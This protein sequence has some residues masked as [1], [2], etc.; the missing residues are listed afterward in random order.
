MTARKIYTFRLNDVTPGNHI[1]RPG[2]ITYRDG[3]LYYHDGET[4]GG[5]VIGGGG[6]GGPTSW[7][8]VTG[9]PSFATVATSGA[10]A[11]LTGKPTLFSGAY[12]DLT[13]KPTLFSGAY[14]DLS[15]KPTLFSGAYADLTGKP[16]L[17]TVATS[18]SYNDLSNKPTLLKGDTGATGAQGAKGD[19]GDTGP[20]GPA[21]A[22]GATGATGA[23]GAAG[24]QGP[25]GLKGDT[26]ATGATGPQGETGLQGPQGPAG[27]TG[28]TGAAGATGATGPI[29]ATGDAGPKGDTGATGAQGPQGDAGPQGPAGND[30]APGATG[31]DGEPG[32]GVPAG[33]TAGQILA[34][35]SGTDYDT[36]WITNLGGSGSGVSSYNDL[37]DK[38]FIP[39]SF[40][41]LGITAGAD[42]QILTL[43]SSLTPVWATPSG[44]SGGASV[45]SALEDVGIDG[46]QAGQV[47]TWN[48][49]SER[50]ENQGLPSVIATNEITNTG[51]EGSTY[52]VSVGTDGVVT[53]VTS[54]GNLEFGALPEPGGPTHFHIMR[55]A[56]QEGS[57]D[58]YFG[59]D[60]NYVKLPGSYGA[61]TLGVEIGAQDGGIGG[62]S[63]WRFGTDGNIHL[64]PGG[65]ILDSNSN[66]VLGGGSSAQ[67]FDTVNVNGE[68]AAISD[69]TTSFNLVAGE[70]ISITSGVNNQITIAAASNA[71]PQYGYFNELKHPG[72]NNRIN[73]EA[74]AMDSDGNSYVSYSYYD[75]NES[76]DF[77]GVMK[78]DSTG[79]KLW[80][81]NIAS[82][83]SYARYVQIASLEYSTFDGEPVLVALGRYYD[84]DTSKDVAFMCYINPVSGSVGE[85]L[86]DAELSAEYG[87]V[88]K[89]GVFGTDGNN[90][91]FA[92]IVGETYSQ[93]VQKTLT[94]LAGSTVDKVIFSW[95]DI[96]AAGLGN[97]Q[98]IYFNDNG[99][100][101]GLTI[102]NFDTSAMPAGSTDPSWYGIS[103]AISATQ[104]GS[105]VITRVNGWGS[106]QYGWSVPQSL[107]ILGSTLGGVDGVND[108]TFDFDRE[109]FAN[110]SSNIDAAVSNIQGTPASSDV[111]CSANGGRD[112]ANNV[113][114][115]ITF[116]YQLGNQA[117]IARFGNTAS[118]TKTIGAT[119]YDRL[120]SVV[121][122]SNG[123]SYAVGYVGGA[124]NKSSLVIK[125]D[126]DG[127]Q[128][129]AV[130]I[131]RPSYTGNE[132]TS[133]DLLGDG[134]LITVD[135]DGVVTKLSS[136]DGS[137]IW[138]VS[139]D[140]GPSW[141]GNFKGTSTPDGDYIIVNYEDNDYTMYVMKVSGS[142]GSSIWNK[143][144][145]RTY[146]GDQGEV[147]AEDDF[148]AQYIDCNATHVTIAGSSDPYSGDRVGLVFS[149]PASGEN[150][151]GTYGQYVIS[152]ES[153]D[154]TT[155][156]TTSVAATV[157][158]SAM[159]VTA[160]PTSP[161]S[162]SSN[163]TVTQTMMGGEAVVEPTVISWTN[164]NNNV[165]RI[166]DYNGG[167]AVNYDGGNYDAKWFDIANHTSGN[168]NFRGAIIQYHAYVNGGT[169]I[170]TIHL[171]NDYTQQQATHT[172]HLSGNSNLQFVTLWDCNGERGQLYFKTTNGNGS[173]AMIQWTAKVFYGSENNC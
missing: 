53:M 76:K 111:V 154:W 40:S 43:N 56:G 52:S 157:T 6:S 41:D 48:G 108:M 42:G 33:G 68:T 125:Y 30:G 132:L 78:F 128:Q 23:T 100:N 70:G 49:Q 93:T 137:I 149:F 13:G 160:N 45:L 47:L 55:P 156:S 25:Q 27:A 24:A 129:W 11:D 159:S 165:W 131:D 87:M 146:N 66:S 139:A 118:W 147:L 133:I 173:N 161:T 164:P 72:D 151:D 121:V 106:A 153:L 144:I 34:K 21:G 60:Y 130:Y 162:T 81:V 171:A 168:S 89:D 32:Q 90:N 148:N 16:S 123:Y 86:I 112:W 29:G 109:V 74:V 145:T 117:Y 10:Y 3:Y 143:R 1:G 31:N 107:T 61:G 69:G 141:D 46:V 102:N 28:D 84:N 115:P 9:K 120:N 134:N 65:N 5:E 105:Y 77:G 172:E 67:Y 12:V 119:S 58:L 37:T 142:D 54:R 110:N 140:N 79:A 127:N 163:I 155:Q 73:G 57:S 124:G 50:W 20:Q 83:N 169:I 135:E 64:P 80:S 103:L 22:D 51:A 138:Q 8:S 136:G 113:G 96:N 122:D 7:T 92:V 116:D 19:T 114:T 98:Q 101:Y 166:E 167:A 17:A 44:G 71:S 26:G 18:G 126:I 104:S 99:T 75:N 35:I 170:G 85:P 2:E 4:A 39:T 59:D 38:P 152:S 91:P 150:T 15:G 62:Q 63:V 95:A 158:D 94:P 97:G 82:Q 88:L 14:A 36:E